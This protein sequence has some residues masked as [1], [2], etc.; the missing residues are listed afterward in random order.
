MWQRAVTV[1]ASG[2]GYNFQEGEQLV[3]SSGTTIS[4]DFK[5]KTIVAFM[6]NVYSGTS[7][8]AIMVYNEDTSE[9][10]AYNKIVSSA[11]TWTDLQTS[12]ISNVTD[13][14]FTIK[15]LNAAAW[16]SCMTHWIAIG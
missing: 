6:S 14:G 8:D 11:G 1:G 4:T 15:T 10:T 7:Y 12:Y 16:P 13:S 2:G 3:S 9:N 5:P